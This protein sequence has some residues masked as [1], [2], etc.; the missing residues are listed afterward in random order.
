MVECED[1][2]KVIGKMYAKVAFQYMTAMMEIIPEG[3]HRRDV[4]R[5][6][7]ELVASLTRISTQLKNSKDNIARKVIKRQVLVNLF[8]RLKY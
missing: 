2:N 3:T 4:L 8:F 7:G 6:Q 1:K 5:R